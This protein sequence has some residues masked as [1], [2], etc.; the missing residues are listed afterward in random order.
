[1]SGR[2]LGIAGR[3]R[4]GKGSLADIC[5]KHGYKRLYFALPLKNM[6]AD[7]LQISVD[8]LNRLKNEKIELNVDLM[9]DAVDF[10]SNETDIQKETVEKVIKGKRIRDVR[11]MLQFIGTDL[12][13]AYNMNWHVNK[14]RQMIEPDKK[15]VI[16]DIRFSNEKQM[17]EDMGGDNWFVVRPN[18][19]NVSHHISEESLRWQDFGDKVIINNKSLEYL[20]M[21][22]ENFLL[23]YEKS[24]DVRE[25]YIVD[26]SLKGID[27]W[28]SHIDEPF[29][30]LDSLFISPY[31]FL[32]EKKELNKDLIKSFKINE[33]NQAVIEYGDSVI[34]IANPL[35]IEDLKLIV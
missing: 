28:N 33:R 7:F 20:E 23:N 35:V 19:D 32:Y 25:K 18:I 6:C 14:I 13:R 4:S 24:N 3:C 26:I 15:Y 12:I 22:W 2:I 8:E 29:T 1:M 11:D 21:T 34:I 30:L 5:E 10:F 16:E 9:D 17:V 27:K 31:Y